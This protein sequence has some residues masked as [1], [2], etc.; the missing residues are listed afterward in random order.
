MGKID[1]LIILGIVFSIWQRYRKSKAKQ[2]AQRKTGEQAKPTLM[3]VW[4]EKTRSLREV[5]PGQNAKPMLGMEWQKQMEQ[6]FGLA[7]EEEE[8]PAAKEPVSVS[9]VPQVSYEKLHFEGPPL[10]DLE[11]IVLEPEKA[12]VA[13][14]NIKDTNWRQGLIMAEILAP[15]VAKRQGFNGV[16]RRQRII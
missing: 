13:A 5:K 7:E 3:Q 4:D 16:S 15:P 11:E 8:K 1:I 6:L 2:E 10:E 12:P 9:Q 14:L